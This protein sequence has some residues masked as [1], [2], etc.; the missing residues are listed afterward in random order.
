MMMTADSNK[1]KYFFLRY[2]SLSSN[3]LSHMHP[4]NLRIFIDIQELGTA[5]RASAK[6]VDTYLGSDA[7]PR[8]AHAQAAW[9]NI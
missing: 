1:V 3:P 6:R 4:R 5:E 7:G 8:H 9:H 2:P